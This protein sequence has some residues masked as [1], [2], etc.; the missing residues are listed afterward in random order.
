MLAV[1]RTQRQSAEDLSEDADDEGAGTG[2]NGAE[3]FFKTVYKRFTKE[4]FFLPYQA[5]GIKFKNMPEK[6]WILPNYEE[7]EFDNE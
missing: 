6:K 4:I 7:N 2:Q 3:N 5:T 1:I